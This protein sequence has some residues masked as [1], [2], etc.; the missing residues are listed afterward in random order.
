MQRGKYDQFA[1]DD[2][3]LRT[4]RDTIRED[5]ARRL[6]HICSHMSDSEFKELV[7]SMADQKLKGERTKSL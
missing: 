3:F 4:R 1:N 6:R 5:I 2:A 7:N